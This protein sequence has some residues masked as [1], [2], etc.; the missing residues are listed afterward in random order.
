METQLSPQDQAGLRLLCGNNASMTEVIN[1]VMARQPGS[2][3]AHGLALQSLSNIPSLLA[4][5]A[6]LLPLCITQARGARITDVDGHEYIDCHMNATAAVLGHNPAPVVQAV[7]EA[8]QRGI[9]GGHFFHEHVELGELVRRLVPGL[10]RV[11]FFHTRGEAIMASARLARS[12][13]GKT[14][15][16]KFE[17][18]YHGANDIGLHNPW[19]LLAGQLPP[20]PLEHIPPLAAT[21][22][23]RTDPDMLILPFNVPVAIE[24]IEQH[25]AELAGVVIDPLPPFM[26]R[27]PEAAKR[28]TSEVCAVAAQQGVPVIFDEFSCGFR[29][30]KGGAREWTGSAPQ[31]SCYGAITSGLGLPLALVGGEARF[32]DA[33]RTNGL[34]RDYFPPKAW[35]T[36]TFGSSFLPVVA[37]LAQLRYLAEHYDTLMERLDRQSAA[38]RERLTDFANRAGIPVALVGHPR[39]GFHLGIGEPEPA[40]KTYRGVM[41]GMAPAQFRTLMALTF[42]LRLHGIYTKM[43]PTMNLSTA[44][45]AEDIAQIAAGISQSLLQM[46]QDGML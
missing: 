2:I 25:A 35:L 10:E 12:I 29:V 5:E 24:L 27:W 44:H 4:Y 14:R 41:Q 23:M 40:E 22:G 9:A 33:T 38:L 11:S 37:A 6:P 8:A 39:V 36:S 28:F 45:T 7:Q 20:S 13:T 43:I 34:F 32:L 15:L 19:M 26:A 3:A 16:A 21:G 17:G 30:A 46:Q 18:C 31:M 1:R 42:Y